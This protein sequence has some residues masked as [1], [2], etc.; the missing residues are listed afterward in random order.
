MYIYKMYVRYDNIRECPLSNYR[1]IIE[2][3]PICKNL[4]KYGRNNFN[5]TSNLI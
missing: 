3:G 5:G 2:K 4:G 1:K